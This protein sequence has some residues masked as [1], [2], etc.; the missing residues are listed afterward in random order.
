MEQLLRAAEELDDEED[1]RFGRDKRG[2]EMPEELAFREGRLRKIREAMGA[3]EAEVE[4]ASDEAVSEGGGDGGVPDESAQ[5]NF[6]DPESRIMPEP[7]VRQFVQ[8]YN[9]Q[10]VVDSS[11]QV[12][13][14]ARA[15]K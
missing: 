8:A 4:A 10:A 5:R 6:T 15:T 3:L 11:S 9:C 7:G 2:D 13:V 1:G 14:A 12:I